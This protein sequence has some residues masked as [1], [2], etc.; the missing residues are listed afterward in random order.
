MTA[1][2]HKVVAL[3]GKLETAER[4]AVMESFRD[5]K[6]KVL[7]TTNVIARGIDV[8]QV[9]MVVNYDLPLDANNKP[10]PETYLHR[11]G[12]FGVESTEEGKTDFETQYRTDGS[13]RSP[14]SFDQLCSRQ[15]VVPGYGGDSQ[16]SGQAYRPSRHR[17]FRADGGGELG[18]VRR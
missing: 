6:T 9:N 14:G 11:I 7:I 16:G 15:A 12:E 3:H 18:C 1:E 2:G 17:G 5:G 8:M 4:D 13:L 10:D